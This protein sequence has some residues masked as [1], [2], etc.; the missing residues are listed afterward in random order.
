MVLT[1]D[2]LEKVIKVEKKVTDL[3]CDVNSGSKAGR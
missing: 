3:S 2:I 1:V